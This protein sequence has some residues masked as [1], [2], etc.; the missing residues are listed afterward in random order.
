MTNFQPF[1]DKIWDAVKSD[2]RQSFEKACAD[3]AEKVSDEIWRLGW[4]IYP[5]KIEDVYDLLDDLAEWCHE[6][7]KKA[8]ECGDAPYEDVSP[9]EGPLMVKKVIKEEI[10]KWRGKENADDGIQQQG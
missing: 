6:Q 7:W 2:D 1:K 10:E 5:K 4:Q 8:M 3:Y 9:G